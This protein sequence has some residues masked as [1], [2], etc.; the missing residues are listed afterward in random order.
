MKLGFYEELCKFRSNTARSTHFD[1]SVAAL[2]V[3]C[4]N[5]KEESDH[6]LSSIQDELY[7][8]SQISVKDVPLKE[9]NI[10]FVVDG[11]GLDQLETALEIVVGFSKRLS[12]SE[13]HPALLKN[14][15]REV[16]QVEWKTD[17]EPIPCNLAS[18]ELTH[19][20][21]IQKKISD[22][23]QQLSKLTGLSSDRN[24]IESEIK[25]LKEEKDVI[26]ERHNPETN[27]RNGP[28]FMLS[29]TT[30]YITTLLQYYYELEVHSWSIQDRELA[31]E[32]LVNGGME[33]RKAHA[34][35]Q[36]LRSKIRSV[37][38]SESAFACLLRR[39]IARS[40]IPCCFQCLLH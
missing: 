6:T 21:E 8:L 16:G 35:L 40:V 24:H 34:F 20:I 32:G 33:T 5:E 23:Q 13:R 1:P 22:R 4:Y 19:L 12:V 27:P 38:H 36:P 28:G 17:I 39:I 9:M 37:E 2:L 25:K 29:E 15:G 14:G 7:Y 10:M 30:A 18:I 31:Q 3:P 11:S 26:F